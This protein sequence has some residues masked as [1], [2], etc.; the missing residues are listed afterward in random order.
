MNKNLMDMGTA[1]KIL[2]KTN[3]SS[4]WLWIFLIHILVAVCILKY[5][6]GKI[7]RIEERIETI[8]NN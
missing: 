8:K 5:Y 3:Q 6:Q 2:T 7:E 4:I 1:A